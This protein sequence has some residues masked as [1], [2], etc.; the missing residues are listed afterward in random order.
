MKKNTFGVLIF[1]LIGALGTLCLA[2]AGGTP[3]LSTEIRARRATYAVGV[4]IAL[5]IMTTNTSPAPVKVEVSKAGFFCSFVVLDL[6]G[7]RVHSRWEHR[8]GWGGSLFTFVFAPGEAVRA[9][10][11]ITKEYSIAA[12]TYSVQAV[13][14]SDTA[15]ASDLNVVSIS[16]PVKVVVVD[17]EELRRQQVSRVHFGR[18]A[19]TCEGSKGRLSLVISPAEGAFG[20]GAPV[21]LNTALTNTSGGTV[22]L[23]NHIRYICDSDYRISIRAADGGSP[24]M[25]ECHRSLQG[26]GPAERGGGGSDELYPGEVQ[27]GSVDLR[28]LFD[29]G[30]GAYT[31]QFQRETGDLGADFEP[32]SGCN[33]GGPAKSD[34]IS[35]AVSK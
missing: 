8:A 17:Q 32:D 13:L 19:A 9:A 2:D 7:W 25:T 26:K 3:G 1:L 23:H 30:P 5:D 24:P 14:H 33:Y 15:H 28:K 35:F 12:G 4:P 18:R 21:V 10:V 16:D 29:L 6:N 11:D 31:V 27:G 22:L 20:P 34:T